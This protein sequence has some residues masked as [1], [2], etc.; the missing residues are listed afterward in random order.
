MAEQDA[1]TP[2]NEHGERVARWERRSEIPMLLLAGA[3]LVAY[4]WPVID[5]DLEPDLYT[6]LETLSW[7]VWLSFGADFVIRV[8]LSEHRLKYALRHWYDVLLI[9]M[10]VFRTLRLLRLFALMRMLNRSAQGGS[11]E[12]KASLYV[13]G[14]ATLTIFLGAVTVL[15]I[16]RGAPDANITELGDALWWAL[17]TAT[18]VGYGDYY[19]VTLEGRLVAVVLMIMGIGLMGVVTAAA[20]SWFLRSAAKNVSSAP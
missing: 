5:P 14:A 20:A 9:L 4:A 19:P 13:G 3:F 16:E 8:H 6:V 12:G 7:T 11:L 10:P 2:K 18:T 17:V 1:P 15:D